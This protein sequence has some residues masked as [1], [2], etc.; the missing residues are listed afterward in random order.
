MSY[1]IVIDS[2][3]ELTEEM[4]KSGRFTSAPLT[5]QVD[6]HTVVD[7][8]TFDQA[9]F[10]K[11]VAASPNCPKSSCPSPEAYRDA[12]DCGVDHAYAVTL[13]AELSGSYNSAMLGKNLYLEQQ[14]EAKVY[15]FNSRSASVGE[16]LIGLKI[17]ECEEAGMS[18]EQ[19]VETVE[20]YIAG[21]NTW[22]VLENLETLRKNG[23]LSTVKA[24]VASALK[25][26]P[27]MGATPE[28]TIIQLGQA[29]GMQK[30][31][32]QMVETMVAEVK[33][34]E[35]KVM[36]IVHCNNRE[37]AEYVKEEVKK[38]LKV[39]DIFI[40]ETG[41]I[42]TLYAAQGGIIMII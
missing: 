1:R 17:Q 21:Q 4:K 34:P 18:F 38:V 16:T 7:D 28:G 35:E 42:S 2:C 3:G 25:I 27:V 33:N 15:V 24:M 41:G 20:A 8:E 5:L 32:R 30:A 36:G 26:K 23:R 6:E 13:S 14:P 37:R 19:V 12:F 40:L 9:D 29:R 31:L 39:K 22:F 11:R 10:L